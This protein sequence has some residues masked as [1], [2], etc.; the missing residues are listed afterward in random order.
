MRRATESGSLS[1][2]EGSVTPT[3]PDRLVI[4]RIVARGEPDDEEEEKSEE[5][6]EE[7]EDE[8]E[9]GGCEVL[10]AP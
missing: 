2:K 3:G 10:D 8:D 6:E 5:E 4:G 1:C 9:T 7:E